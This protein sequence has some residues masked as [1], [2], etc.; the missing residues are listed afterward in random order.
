MRVDELLR[1]ESAATFLAL[2]AVCTVVTAFRA[3]SDDVAV[4]QELIALRIEKLLGLALN[5][6]A[7]FV[8]LLEEFSRCCVMNLRCPKT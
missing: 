1:A 7:F 8:K 6:L 5:E 3:C 4:A 2:V